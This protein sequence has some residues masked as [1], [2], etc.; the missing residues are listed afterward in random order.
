[1]L[2]AILF[3]WILLQLHAPGWTYVL[4]AVSFAVKMFE[5]VW[6]IKHEKE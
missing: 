3:L 2:T 6:K 4:V 5:S 1:M